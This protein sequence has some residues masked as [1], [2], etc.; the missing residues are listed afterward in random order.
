MKW[1]ERLKGAYVV[2]STVVEGNNVEG[3]ESYGQQCEWMH[4][5]ANRT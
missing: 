4:P 1:Q 2:P 5:G 3:M